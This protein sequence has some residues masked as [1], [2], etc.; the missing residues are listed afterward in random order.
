MSHA[1]S[2]RPCSG[3]ALESLRHA[4]HVLSTVPPD[5]NEDEEDP[6]ILAHSQ[7]LSEHA[8]GYKWV[9]YISSTSGEGPGR[10]GDG[11]AGR[12]AAGMEVQGVERACLAL[13]ARL[14]SQV[15]APW[16]LFLSPAVPAP[17][18]NP[19]SSVWRLRGRVGG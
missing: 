5:A 7:Q 13:C 19:G 10:V 11:E 17:R 14:S 8:D 2:P 4:T 1:G 12:G 16:T 3:K 6:V 18:C 9:G 15:S